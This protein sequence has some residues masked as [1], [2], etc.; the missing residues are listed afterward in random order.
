MGVSTVTPGL[1]QRA[2]SLRERVHALTGDDPEWMRLFRDRSMLRFNEMGLPD[3]TDEEWRFTP[4]G[5]IAD[6]AFALPAGSNSS[7]EVIADIAFA[8]APFARLVFVDGILSS[9]L[10]SLRGLPR[11]VDICSLGEAAIRH[12]RLVEPWLGAISTGGPSFTSLNAALFTDGAFINVPAGVVV[13]TPVHLAFLTTRGDQAFMTSPRA[14]VLVG[15]SGSLSLLETYQGAGGLRRLTN[16]VTE[17]VVGRNAELEHYRLQLE[18]GDTYHIGRTAVRLD[19]DSRYTSHAVSIGSSLSRH[20]LGAVLKGENA[21]CTMNGLYVGVGDQIHDSH[22]VI[23]HATPNCESHELYKGILNDR[24]RGVFNGKVLVRPDAQK[25]DAKQTNQALLLSDGARV[26]TKPQL[27]IFA[28]DVRCTH[29]ATVGQLDADS[30]FYLRSRGIAAGDA[31]NVLIHAFA[32]EII[33]RMK[34]PAVRHHLE[35]ILL[36]SLPS[37]STVFWGADDRAE[38]SR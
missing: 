18:P 10:S 20:D 25:T 35:G 9:D 22:T 15:E 37:P 13:E 27:E 23:D 8:D 28:D 31:R 30:L 24:S 32:S 21:L 38:H 19:R 4:I 26:D 6:T 11:E 1:E 36:A 5:P 29:G 12:P 2:Q 3:S 33:D 34:L 17:A 7:A 14:L 16:S